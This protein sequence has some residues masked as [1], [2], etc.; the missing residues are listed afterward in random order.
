MALPVA[1]DLNTIRCL[2]LSVLPGDNPCD[3]ALVVNGDDVIMYALAAEHTLKDIVRWFGERGA[4]YFFQAEL[5]YDVQA[6][7]YSGYTVGPDV[8]VHR[9]Y[10]AGVYHYFRDFAVTVQSAITCPVRSKL[11]F[12]ASTLMTRDSSTSMRCSRP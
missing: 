5:P 6:Y 3:N 10:G 11:T 2:C 9:S 1:G 4:S 12:T 8:A 7:P